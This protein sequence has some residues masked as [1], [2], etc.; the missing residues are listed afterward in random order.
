MNVLIFVAMEEEA[1][2][3]IN[4]LSLQ[5]GSAAQQLPDDLDTQVYHR[6]IGIHDIWL[7]MSGKD[8]V[9]PD[10]DCIGPLIQPALR[11]SL[12]KFKPDMIINAGTAGAIYAAGAEKHKVYIA[13][14]AMSHDLHFPKSDEKHRALAL[15][16]YPVPDESVLAK[17]LG[18][19]CARLSTTGSMKTTANG[20]KQL[21]ENKAKLVDME[22]KYI[23]QSILRCSR[24]DYKPRYMAVK[25]TTD[26]IDT[27]D[28]PQEQFQKSMKDSDVKKQLA[29][30]CQR[31]IENICQIEIFEDLATG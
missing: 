4:H 28:C 24:G 3:L 7:T 29:Q 17:A 23:V 26:F 11:E 1:T 20:K 27:Q 12:L 18:F 30:A 25:V 15:G 13:T 16:N 5:K 8:P 2:A 10:T 21:T 9:Y 19:E 14:T 31:I 6:Q 22:W